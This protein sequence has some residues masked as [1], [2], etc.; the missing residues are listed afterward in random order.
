[1]DAHFDMDQKCQLREPSESETNMAA[2]PPPSK[3]LTFPLCPFPIL[4]VPC[5]LMSLQTYLQ[6]EV[7]FLAEIMIEPFEERKL[8]LTE[9]DL[10]AR[11][12]SV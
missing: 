9:N 10:C 7:S 12:Y 8:A 4:L 5:G 11:C 6:M 2:S 3:F 1:M